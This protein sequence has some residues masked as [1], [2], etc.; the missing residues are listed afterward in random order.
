[1]KKLFLLLL[2]LLSGCDSSDECKKYS[3]YTCKEIEVA[4]YNVLF[5][6]PSKEKEYFLGNVKGLN[7]C[8]VVAYSFAESKK[9]KNT[10]GWDY[11]CCMQTKK[12]VC[13]EK[14]R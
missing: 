1:M 5:Y 9:L 2:F 13:E 10:D 8:G 11:V 3:N 14:H 6:F 7:Q 12:S 4:S